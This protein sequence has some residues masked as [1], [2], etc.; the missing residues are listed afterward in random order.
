[1]RND[2]ARMTKDMNLRF[3]IYDLRISDKGRVNRKS[4]IV[5]PF[6]LQ[7]ARLP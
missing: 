7:A 2:E 3:T 6:A 4:E 1:M 5:N